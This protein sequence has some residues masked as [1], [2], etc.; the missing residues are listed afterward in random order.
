MAQEVYVEY[1]FSRLS[2]GDRKIV[3]MELVV[4]LVF[5]AEESISVFLLQAR[6]LQAGS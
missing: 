2:L 1:P 4:T 5:L 3:L 6:P